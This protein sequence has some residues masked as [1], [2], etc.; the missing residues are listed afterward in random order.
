MQYL[1]KPIQVCSKEIYFTVTKDHTVHDVRFIG[2]CDGNAKGLS[3]LVEGMKA[4][5]IIAR[6]S[7]VTCEKKSTSCPDQLAIALKT[8]LSQEAAQK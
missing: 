5:E 4:E 2:G 1:Y 6:L 3:N 8:V 7:G